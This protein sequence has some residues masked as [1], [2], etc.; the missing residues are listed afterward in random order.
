MK[1]NLTHYISF[2]ATAVIAALILSTGCG[3]DDNQT[4]VWPSLTGAPNKFYNIGDQNFQPI[5]ADFIFDN[6]DI[7]VNDDYGN[8]IFATPS[9]QT[10]ARRVKPR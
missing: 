9:A 6:G 5:Q 2:A 4:V 7:Q 3:G 10:G 8:Y 1:P